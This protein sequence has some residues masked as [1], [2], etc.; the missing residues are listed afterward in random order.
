N[1][2]PIWDTYF[3]W[4]GAYGSNDDFL[5]TAFVREQI[6]G[7]SNYDDDGLVDRFGSSQGRVIDL[8]PGTKDVEVEGFREFM[9]KKHSHGRYQFLPDRGIDKGFIRWNAGEDPKTIDVSDDVHKQMAR[10]LGSDDYIGTYSRP[11]L[12]LIQAFYR[13]ISRKIMS[14]M[15]AQ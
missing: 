5:T 1:T 3:H 6:N 11:N 9:R 10:T 2:N 13:L 14:D 8:K 7:N 4:P 12:F 15:S